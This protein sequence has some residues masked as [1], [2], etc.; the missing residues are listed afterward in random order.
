[1][2]PKKEEKLIEILEEF[3]D[4]CIEVDSTWGAEFKAWIPHYI[5]LLKENET[6]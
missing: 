3:T 1:M 6:K 4:F 5:K 2:K